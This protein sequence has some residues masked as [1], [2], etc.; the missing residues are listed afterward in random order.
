MNISQTLDIYISIIFL[1]Y[2]IKLLDVIE[3]KKR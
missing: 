2:K 3:V 1:Y